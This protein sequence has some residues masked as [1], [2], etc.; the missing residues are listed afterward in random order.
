M[1]GTQ[2]L[3]RYLG[4]PI[5]H[6]RNSKH[7]YRYLVERIEAKLAGWKVGSLS[8]AGRVSLALSALNTIPA[9]T[10]QTVLLPNE[11][12][13]A[14]DQK[15]RSFIW[16]SLNGERKM[17]LMN[18]EKVCQPKECGG[19]G[20]RS[21]KE[22]N[23]AFLM[24]LTWGMIKAP[25]SLWASVL[26]TKY[27]KHTSNG[28]VPKKSK[29]WSS[30]W[31]GMN[32]S[33]PIFTGGLFWSIHN[34]K[35]T[36][37]WRERWLDDGQVI[38]DSVQPPLGLEEAVVANFCDSSGAWD[39]GRLAEVLPENILRSVVGMTPPSPDLDDD[40]PVWGLEPH[41]SYSVK[42]GYLLAKEV[43]V[44]EINAIWKRVWSWRGP[45][46]IRQFLWVAIHNRLMTNAE[47]HRRHITNNDGCGLCVDEAETTD[48]LLRGC[49]MAKQVWCRVL[50]ITSSDVFFSMDIED[51]W[52][53][54]LNDK[55]VS[56]IFGITCWLLWKTRNERIF[57][58]KRTS[59]G[60]IVE[61]GKFWLNTTTDAYKRVADLK[62]S[63][64][65][66]KAVK[67]ISWN[68]APGPGCTLNTDGSVITSNRNAAA[69]GCLR[70][71]EGRVVDSFAA[72]LG[73]CSITRAELTGIAIGL[74]RAWQMGIR[75]LE[76]Q[77]DSACA[78]KL[79]AEGSQQSHQHATLI[80]RIRRY[81]QRPWTVSIKLIYREANHLADFLANKGHELA[82]GTHSIDCLERG[83]LYWANYDLVG[84]SE[85]RL[86]AI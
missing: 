49:P 34:G 44:G 83:I 53:R 42:S 69:G 39:V 28:L 31:K 86:V 26:R 16:G 65:Q 64:D 32:E 76:V 71:D 22:M 74:D 7:L 4:V 29:R 27:L 54:F 15:I 12:C 40:T 78:V 25:D 56:I 81:L 59:V 18:W 67:A 58:G 63:N 14:I 10:M 70:N 79:L 43:G 38:G 46:R 61:Q 24:K 52:K 17:H 13:N 48:H 6:G 60:G 20:L 21:A 47:R 19:L 82:L 23:L 72:N 36:N 66:R 3:G 9:Y 41:G 45:Q 73:N 35:R 30:T 33:W 57:E 84:G 77:T 55:E 85:T 68:A 51:W 50:S 2:D 80:E 8:F 37:F 11:V 75:N 1:Q 5:I 62:L